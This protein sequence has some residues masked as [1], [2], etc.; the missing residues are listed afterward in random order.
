M[1]VAR[2]KAF[3]YMQQDRQRQGQ[4]IQMHINTGSAAPR[5]P[6]RVVLDTNVVL[7]WLVFNDVRALRLA[8]AL[9]QGQLLWMATEPMLA[10]LGHVMSRPFIAPWCTDTAAVLAT[11]RSK[12]HVL[13]TPAMD[14]DKAPVCGDPDYQQFIDL[15][16]SVPAAWLFSRDRAL[17][18]LAARARARGVVITT[19]QS[20]LGLAAAA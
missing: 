15:A 19:P 12:C 1:L 7:D 10:E 6:Y 3:D 18:K 2:R 20:W 9:A 11:A 14:P 8:Q 4:A 5:P 17:L 13:P 16:W